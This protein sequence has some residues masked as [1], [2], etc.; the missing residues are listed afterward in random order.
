M[1]IPSRSRFVLPLVAFCLYLE[2]S[3]PFL[4]Q[5]D[6][7]DYL[8]QI[9]THRLS[10]LGIG[11]PVYLGYNILIW[12]SLRKVFRLEPLHLE[13]VAMAGTVLLGVAGVIL[14]RRLAGR[15]LPG[16]AADMAALALAVSPVYAVYSGYI[17]TEVPMLVALLAAALFV[18]KSDRG[19]AA[20]RDVAGGAFFGLAVG[21]RE[22]ALTLGAGFVWMLF[23][24]GND[25]R[26]GFRASARFAAAA[27]AAILAPAAGMVLLDPAGF[28]ARTQTWLHAIPMGSVQF[29]N[30]LEAS[31][32]F[33][34]V[35]CPGAW[36]A[37][38]CAAAARLA[39]PRRPKAPAPPEGAASIRY[40]AW[41]VLCCLVLPV[42]VLWRDADVQM[43]PRYLLIALPAAAILC[44][45]LFRRWIPSGRGLVA[46]A[47]LQVLF[48][49]IAAAALVPY[50]QTQ[51]A[52]MEFARRLRERVPGPAL[53]IAGNCSPI[54]D[55]YRGIGVRPEWD[56]VWSG[57]DWDVE[58]VRSRVEESW[59]RGIPV[60]WST[61][62]PGWSYFERELL[63]ADTL[64]RDCRKEEIQPHLYRILPPRPATRRPVEPRIL[65]ILRIETT[66]KY[67]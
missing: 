12:E 23:A 53:L 60:V 66:H 29:G 31:A 37:L 59:E 18:W 51:T 50:R 56:V 11:R 3:A 21:I 35:I 47:L 52:R 63:E 16:P 9:V 58:T 48:F 61:H 43:H 57:W 17:M 5:W 34:F 65:R 30:N 64:F 42:A 10:A 45:A 27:A 13:L 44:A 49:G 22:Q 4:G 46:W 2:G 41:G 39:A 40:P 25:F 24:R 38:A 62:P 6:S 55:Y 19:H 7:Y 54:L 20:W 32:L 26:G 28:V 33:V 15:M 8:K 1:R 36:I 67:P 14:F